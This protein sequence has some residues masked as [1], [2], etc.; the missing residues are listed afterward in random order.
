MRALRGHFDSDG[1]QWTHK[2]ADQKNRQC[3]GKHLL[4]GAIQV[5]QRVEEHDGGHRTTAK[6]INDRE[7][8][9]YRLDEAD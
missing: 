6:K 4:V 9:D 3:D 7:C 5:A 1:L 2:E 8:W